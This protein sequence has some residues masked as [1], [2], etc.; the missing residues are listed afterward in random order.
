ME[1]RKFATVVE[2]TCLEAGRR[3]APPTRKAAAMAV[4]K[5]PFAGKYV[6]DLSE[7]MDMG[8]ELG[9]ILGDRARDALGI[10]P[11][12]CES[13]GKAAIV[14]LDGELEHGGAILHP[15]LGAPFR[16]ALGRGL[17]LIP[18]VKKRGPA[19]CTIDV[20]LNHKDAA[21]IRSH[22]DGM[23]VSLEDA[24]NPDEIL[25]VLVVTD[26]GRPLPRIG[27]LTKE[28]AKYEDGLR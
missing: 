13:Y 14:G 21:F 25:V 4:V 7:L 17:A 22:F 2:E 15:K 1:I 5:N 23:T 20:P 26:S 27:G 10:G 18:S 28:G 24:P 8:E 6:E 12:K 19:G 11:E 3:I 9:S 16:K